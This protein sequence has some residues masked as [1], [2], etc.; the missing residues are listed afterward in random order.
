MEQYSA[1]H[2]AMLSRVKVFKTGICSRK[3]TLK[4]FSGPLGLLGLDI[5]KQNTA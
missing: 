5:R 1:G 4:T 2:A 3:T